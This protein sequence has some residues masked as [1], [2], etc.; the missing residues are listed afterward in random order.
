MRFLGDCLELQGPDILSPRSMEGGPSHQVPLGGSSGLGGCL[1]ASS[2]L[3]SKL[4]KRQKSVPFAYN[5][6][7]ASTCQAQCQETREQARLM[8]HRYTQRFRW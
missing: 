7:E 5:M 8:G 2:S 6:S 4:W 1:A 3:S